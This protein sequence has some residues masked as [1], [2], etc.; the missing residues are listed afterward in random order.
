MDE[1][2]MK[3]CRKRIRAL[4]Y[5][6]KILAIDDRYFMFRLLGNEMVEVTDLE[7]G[8]QCYVNIACDNVPAMVYDI[9]KQAGDW[10]L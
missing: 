8:N 9:L 3:E 10:I 5:L 1:L 2:M 7:S 4:I 6:E